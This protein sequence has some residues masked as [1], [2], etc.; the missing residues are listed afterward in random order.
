MMDAP[1]MSK[2]VSYVQLFCSAELIQIIFFLF[3]LFYM[4]VYLIKRFDAIFSK[5]PQLDTVPHNFTLQ[6]VSA[7]TDVNPNLH[8]SSFDQ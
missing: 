1:S 7:V 6:I 3:F 8:C 2:W 5:F 4:I